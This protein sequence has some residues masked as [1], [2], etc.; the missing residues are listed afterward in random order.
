MGNYM[1]IALA[2]PGSIGSVYVAKI[3]SPIVG[4]GNY[5][6]TEANFKGI[7]QYLPGWFLVVATPTAN[8]TIGVSTDNGTTFASIYTGGG[9]VYVDGQTNVRIQVVSTPNQI[10]IYPMAR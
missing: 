1:P 7:T 8:T 2:T 4:T 3:A 6:F 9:W 10:Y 5:L